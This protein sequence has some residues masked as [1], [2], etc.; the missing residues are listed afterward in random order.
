M[1]HSIG[2]ERKKV[3]A[4]GTKLGLNKGTNGAKAK[5]TKGASERVKKVA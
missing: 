1:G 3:I 2:P 4:R 5:R